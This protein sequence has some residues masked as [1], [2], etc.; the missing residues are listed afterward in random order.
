VNSTLRLTCLVS[1]AYS[2]L[3]GCSSGT[4]PSNPSAAGTGGS[5]AGASGAGSGSAGAPNGGSANGG[6][7]N[8]AGAGGQSS[9]GT[10]G[11]GTAGAGTAGAGTAG[12][13]SAGS[14]QG[15]AGAGGAASHAGG[16][17]S[18]GASNT[19]GAGGDPGRPTGLVTG[20]AGPACPMGECEKDTCTS[21]YPAPLT[22]S[23]S[24]CAANASGQY[25]LVADGAW[26]IVCAS[27]APSLAK[28]NFGCASDHVTLTATCF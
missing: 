25:C 24:L 16:G 28:C 5:E 3:V 10:A 4:S 7:A 21:L 9:S 27:G 23:S 17:G 6:S 20:C 8:G 15:G 12:A 1:I 13:S 18:S 2:M 22:A 26:A 19:A 14:N 11:A